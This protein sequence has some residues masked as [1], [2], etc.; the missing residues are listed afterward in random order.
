MR[1]TGVKTFKCDLCEKTFVQLVS[2]TRHKISHTELNN[3][4]HTS[5]YKN[6]SR[7]QKQPTFKFTAYRTALN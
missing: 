6:I 3:K 5:C 7:V 2:L 4:I 1:Q